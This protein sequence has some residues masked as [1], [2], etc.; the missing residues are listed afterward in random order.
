MTNTPLRYPGGKSLMTD[1]FTRFISENQLRNTIYAEPYCGGA[2]AGINLLLNDSID[3]LWLNDA[4][5]AIYSFWYSIKHLGDEFLRLFD[6]TEVTLSEWFLQKKVFENTDLKTNDGLL[7]K[8]FATFFLNRTN[9][10]GIIDAG[11]IGGQTIPSQENANYKI[12]ARFNKINLR[13]KLEKIIGLSDRIQVFNLDAL[14]FLSVL[15][16][17]IPKYQKHDFFVYLDPPYYTQGSSLYLNYYDKKDHESISKFLKQNELNFKW[18]LSYD[19]VKPIRELY[20]EFRTYNF[21]LNYHVQESKM[22]KELLVYSKNSQIPKN[23]V[24]K[25]IKAS[26]KK[27][28]LI[29]AS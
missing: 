2:G 8:G 13:P 29:K 25:Y 4:S 15:K 1:F 27:I 24:L 18:I 20:S 9:R 22:G 23:L 5:S 17:P 10:S 19:S 16:N 3:E 28:E 14:D 11:P 7:K 26:K 21:Y 6:E 12:D